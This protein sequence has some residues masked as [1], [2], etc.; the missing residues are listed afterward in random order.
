MSDANKRI[1]L[2]S[3]SLPRWSVGH[4]INGTYIIKD[5]L[6]ESPFGPATLLVEYSNRASSGAIRA[7]REQLAD[8]FET[9]YVMKLL[10]KE[11][12]QTPDM[13]KAFQRVMDTIGTVSHSALQELR[14]RGIAEEGYPYALLQYAP[15]QTLDKTLDQLLGRPM[16]VGFTVY[17]HAIVLD[18]LCELHNKQIA[19]RAIE[20]ENIL[21]A[22]NKGLFEPGG[23]KLLGLSKAKL[24]SEDGSD[25]LGSLEEIDISA[26]HV[27]P[28]L[29]D[30]D[31]HALYAGDQYMVGMSLL[32]CLLGATFDTYR[33]L[34]SDPVKREKLIHPAEFNSDVREDLD[35]AVA[36]LL[37]EDPHDRYELIFDAAEAFKKLA[38]NYPPHKDYVKGK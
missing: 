11:E 4:I 5:I 9:D 14:G 7:L 35:G 27:P 38:R 26:I 21:R 32:R 15:G 12:D 1:T 16:D 8:D 18:A 30:N 10:P 22:S 33:G 17:A 28:D 37:A 6:S 3:G 20:P 13:K 31:P 25:A 2:S 36:Q 29:Q 34:L 19:H 24:I 23:I